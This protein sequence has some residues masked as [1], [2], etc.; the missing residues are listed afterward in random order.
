MARNVGS[1]IGN[2]LSKGLITE[3][4]GMNFPENA[5]TD[6][7]NVVFN[8]SGSVER[9]KGFDVEGSAVA[10]SYGSEDGIIKEFL[11]RSVA[12]TGG[13]TFLVMQTGANIH[14]YEV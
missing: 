6:A 13:Y 5:V 3:A 10:S 4:T 8:P 11:W 14:F 9:R 7:E 12:K 2:N 1:V